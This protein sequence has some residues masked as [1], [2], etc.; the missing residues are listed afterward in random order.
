MLP[1]LFLA[2]SPQQ[3]AIRALADADLRVATVGDRLATSGT[4]FCPGQTTSLGGLVIQ[5]ARQYAAP[6]RAD[7]KLALKLGD[8]PTVVAS[9]GA[10]GKA[11]VGRPILAV[12]GQPVATRTADAYAD[13]GRAE[14]L[15]EAGFAHGKVVLTLD[16]GQIVTLPA[17]AGCRSRF[18][19]TKGGL[20][21][22]QSDGR[23]VQMSD[24]ML[25]FTTND[26]ELAAVLAHELAHSVLGHQGKKISSKQAEYEADWLSVW[27]I[28]RA[29]YDIDAIV[30]FWTR[31]GKRTDYGIL[32]DGSHPGWKHRVA[33][34]AEAVA[35][36]TDQR[37]SGQPL[38]PAQ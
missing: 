5:D 18:Q 26:D 20:T 36:V 27:L 34:L 29:G 38:V 23:Y 33:R 31:L 24:G 37:K 25:A 9:V 30:P 14:A 17:S 15:I 1:L 12:D 28:A 21:R 19:I 8:G 4:V 7:A 6:L 35:K 10:P 32:S 11:I 16:H 3:A 13:V 22:T 2:L